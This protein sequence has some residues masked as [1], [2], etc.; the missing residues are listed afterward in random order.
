MYKL[1]TLCEHQLHTVATENYTMWQSYTQ[2]RRCK[3]KLVSRHFTKCPYLD[4][5]L[6]FQL[7]GKLIPD[8]INKQATTA[9]AQGSYLNIF[10]TATLTKKYLSC[11]CSH[12]TRSKV[13]KNTFENTAQK[14]SCHDELLSTCVAQFDI[15]T[16]WHI[17]TKYLKESKGSFGLRFSS[18]G[19]HAPNE[20]Y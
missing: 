18:S 6:R 16:V 2:C 14:F 5:T 12:R 1:S 17:W 4:K 8:N 10:K 13:T 19:Y 15:S 7:C 9:L 20:K 3:E 11:H